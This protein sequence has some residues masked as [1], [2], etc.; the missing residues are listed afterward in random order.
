[1]KISNDT[2]IWTTVLYSLLVAASAVHFC[3]VQ[4]SLGYKLNRFYLLEEKNCLWRR[5]NIV[6]L[7]IVTLIFA[8][9]A[10]WMYALPI[11]VAP[12]TGRGGT[13]CARL[14]TWWQQLGTWWYRVFF[15]TGTLGE[16]T[17]T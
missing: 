12:G 4:V 1:M 17:A 10:F 2:H 14:G 9:S 13:I 5:V 16:S 6:F 8:F 11:Q 7:K 3:R 15:L